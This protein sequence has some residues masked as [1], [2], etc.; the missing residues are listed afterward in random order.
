MILPWRGFIDGKPVALEVAEV[1]ERWPGVYGTHWQVDRP[2]V[3]LASSA[4]R[5]RELHWPKVVE[6]FA[7]AKRED[8]PLVAMARDA[9]TKS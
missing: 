6:L 9:E 5:A 2:G 3:Q 1:R 4:E 7:R 8:G